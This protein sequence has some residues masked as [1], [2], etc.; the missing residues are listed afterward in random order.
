MKG[1]ELTIGGDVYCGALEDGGVVSVLLTKR[2]EEIWLD[3]GGW[4]GN[5]YM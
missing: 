5:V 4:I 1:L 3:L 2:R